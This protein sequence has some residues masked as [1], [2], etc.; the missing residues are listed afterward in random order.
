[1]G[2]FVVRGFSLAKTRA[3]ARCYVRHLGESPLPALTAP[4][5]QG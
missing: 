4:L 2:W 1:M 3:E 5:G